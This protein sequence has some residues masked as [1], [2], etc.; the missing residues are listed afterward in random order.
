M[1]D[2]RKQRF[3]IDAML[4]NI[5][6]WLRILGYDSE[7]W[8]G[9]DGGLIQK[10][11]KEGRIVLTKDRD[12]YVYA[13]RC[14]VEAI[15]IDENGIEHILGKLNQIYGVSLEF[16]PEYT[17]CPICNHLLQRDKHSHREEWSCNNCGKRYWMGRHW[18]NITRILEEA[19]NIGR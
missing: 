18:R 11:I 1:S 7:Y 12:L 8:D 5:V 15:L 6:S 4:G 16:N 2:N 10:A 19:K 9:D 3:L 13:K 17:R 14:G